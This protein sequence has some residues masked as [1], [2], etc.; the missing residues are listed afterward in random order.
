MDMSEQRRERGRERERREGGRR[1]RKEGREDWLNN[2]TLAMKV[3]SFMTMRERGR[4]KSYWRECVCIWFLSHHRRGVSFHPLIF[5]SISFPSFFYYFLS[6]LSFF[7]SF[8]SF[9]L[10]FSFSFFLI[11]KVT[12]WGWRESSYCLNTSLPQRNER[13]ENTHFC[14]IVFGTV[15]DERNYIVVVWWWS[16]SS[17]VRASQ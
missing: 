1:G 10:S 6:L 9:F 17:K 15:D 8:S 2:W 14:S 3:S 7:L 5:L 13:V 11:R 4:E 12:G 16:S